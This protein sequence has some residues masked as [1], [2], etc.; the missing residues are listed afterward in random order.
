MTLPTTAATVGEL[1]EIL[2]HLPQDMKVII[3]D[4][5]LNAYSVEIRMDGEWFGRDYVKREEDVI[6]FD[7]AKAWL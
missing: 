6:V 5:C 1:A 3:N 4:D 2:S 7:I